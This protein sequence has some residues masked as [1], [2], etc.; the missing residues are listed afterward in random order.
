MLSDEEPLITKVMSY[1]SYWQ[2]R[3]DHDRINMWNNLLQGTRYKRMLSDALLKEDRIFTFERDGAWVIF[4]HEVPARS[5]LPRVL[6]EEHIVHFAQEMA[7]F[8]KSCERLARGIPGSTKSIKSDI[9]NLHHM[10]S[11]PFCG[12]SFTHLVSTDLDFVRHQCDIFLGNLDEMGYDYWDRIPVL[13]DWNLGNFS[14]EFAEDGSF[15]FFSRWDYDWFRIEPR[16][17]DFYFCSRV[18]SAI[19]DKTDFSY[20]IDPLVGDRFRLFLRHYNEIYPLHR[21]DL[22]FLKEAYRFFILNYVIKDGEHF[23]QRRICRRLKRE[24]IDEYLPRL[25]ERR[26]DELL[27]VL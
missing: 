25:D 11:D 9:I 24:A 1:G 23:F 12:E 13:I 7:R 22:L 5:R 3:E 6:E 2:F 17:L 19:G 20:L 14:V 27:R 18:V 26:I 21:E 15:S 4:Y 10:I 16:A 8:H